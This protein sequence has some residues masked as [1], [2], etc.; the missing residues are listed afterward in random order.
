MVILSQM[1]LPDFLVIGAAK[2]GTVS[3]YHYLQQHPQ[4]YMSPQNEPNYWALAGADF[5]TCFQGPGD[6]QAIEKFYI[7]E[8]AAYEQLFAQAAPEQCVGESSP[9]YLYS[10]R[11]AQQIRA[12]L[13]QSKLVA[14]LRQP[15][16]RAYSH[17]LHF[18]R[19]GLE[20]LADFA[21]AVKAEPA[22]IA[23]GWGPVPMWHYVQM[24][25]YAA[26]LQR[27]FELFGRQ[28]VGVWLYEQW[29][30]DPLELLQSIFAFLG[31]D[32]SFVPDMAVRH[33]WQGQSQ[34][35]GVLDWLAGRQRL[36]SW[37]R[38]WLPAAVYHHLRHQVYRHSLT[39]AFDPGLRQELSGLYREDIM[40]VQ[41]MIGRDLSHW[42]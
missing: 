2:S 12:Y 39:P 14:I 13:P 31:V 10:A 4:I 19:A 38:Q 35:K 9:V 22:R 30:S 20:P 6:R 36:K 11:A 16:D 34:N 5:A 7:T 8:Q 17:Y 27:Y 32:D 24:G 40:K 33:N 42:V 15:A 21:L 37:A 1:K 28:Q 25:F 18:R 41:A 26:Q 23:Q 29:L 3:L